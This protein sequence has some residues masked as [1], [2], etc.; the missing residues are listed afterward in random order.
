VRALA[1]ATLARVRQQ[2][3][4]GS[5]ADA[6]ADEAFC[7][8]LV[9]AIGSNREL[10]TAQGKLHFAPT[11]AFPALAGDMPGALPVAQSRAQSSNTTVSLG[12]RLFLKLYRHLRAGVNPEVEM[13]RFLTETAGFRNC[14]PVAG[15]LEYAGNDGTAMTLALLQGYVPNQGDGW[16]HALEY[17]EHFLDEYSGRAAHALPEDVHGAFLEL[18]RMLGR[19][20]AEL[21]LALAAGP[22]D[23]AFA[24]E[25][26]AASD[27]AAWATDA[28]TEAMQSLD[29]AE[30]GRAGVP[31]ALHEE[32]HRL[33]TARPSL[34][35]RIRAAAEH[36]IE[37]LKIRHHGDYHLGQVLLSKNDFVI[38]D[39]EGEPA[40]PLA[41]RRRKH[42]PLKDVAG[43]LRSFNYVRH[44]ALLHVTEHRPDTLAVLAPLA[45]SW[46][47]QVRESFLSAYAQH[48]EG[49][50]LYGSFAAARPLLE[51][52]EL[53]KAFYELRY[54]LGHRPDWAGV[55]LRGILAYI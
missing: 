27:L 19:R 5:L 17:L 3:A 18:M 33:V 44:A 35:A 48:V 49:H 23:P 20:T 28:A 31:A 37:G 51:L 7:R 30:R 46:E 16:T 26:I 8:A 14:V 9:E 50:P 12:E 36:P 25:P 2:A 22:G 40:R 38:I 47:K 1:P 34:L 21:H 55:P 32:V 24:P 52:F 45:E 13:G 15:A 54:E 43:M 41:Q 6:L 11:R 53:E 39:F 10:A 42:S 29:Q 4:V